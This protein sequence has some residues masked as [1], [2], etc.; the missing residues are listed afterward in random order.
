LGQTSF[1]GQLDVITHF[2]SASTGHGR[3]RTIDATG[4]DSR[5]A[6]SGGRQAIL[7]RDSEVFPLEK[8]NRVVK[9]VV[10]LVLPKGAGEL[11]PF[12]PSQARSQCVPEGGEDVHSEDDRFSNTCLK[13]CT[14]ATRLPRAAQTSSPTQL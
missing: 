7:T 6:W 14:S 9:A 8:G 3:F 13:H 2:L 11:A 10:R 1:I 5:I 4:I 12:I